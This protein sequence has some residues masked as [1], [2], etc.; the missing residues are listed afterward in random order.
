MRPGS[1]SPGSHGKDTAEEVGEYRQSDKPDA[2]YDQD[3]ATPPLYGRRMSLDPFHRLL[4][5]AGHQHRGREEETHKH[6][7]G[8]PER[9]ERSPEAS[10]D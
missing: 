4:L 8:N 5:G 6:R 7:G 3:P 1:A 9:G 2:H 10:Q